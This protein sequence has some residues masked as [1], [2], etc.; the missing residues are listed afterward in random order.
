MSCQTVCC[1]CRTSVE[2]EP[3]K[4]QDKCTQRYHRRVVDLIVCSLIVISFSKQNAECQCRDTRTDVYHIAAGK[5]YRTDLCQETAVCPDH[6]CHGVVN[7]KTPQYQEHEQ[8]LEFHSS[9]YRTCNQRRGN[10][11]KH[12]LKQAENHVRNPLPFYVW[13]CQRNAF[14]TEP[15]EITDHTAVIRS[16][17][18]GITNQHPHHNAGCNGYYRSKHCVHGV[19]S[20]YQTAVETR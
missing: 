19:F 16:E 2:S 4:Q 10:Y 5:V 17:R 8:R 3:S 1:Q 11:C 18:K 13:F 20:S 14:Q 15:A 7:H 6:V 12:H 9:G